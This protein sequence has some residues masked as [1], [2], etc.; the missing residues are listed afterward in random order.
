M[1]IGDKV[2][3]IIQDWH[4]VVKT[5]VQYIIKC[6]SKDG[7]YIKVRKSNGSKNWVAAHYFKVVV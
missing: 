1:K 5:N 6:I 2:E 3:L 7:K 4:T